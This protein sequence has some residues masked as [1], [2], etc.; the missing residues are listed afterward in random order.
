MERIILKGSQ[1][2]SETRIQIEVLID[3]LSPGNYRP[4][5]PEESSIV[6]NAPRKIGFARDETEDDR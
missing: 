5:T 3:D 4:V 6:P 2:R 1:V